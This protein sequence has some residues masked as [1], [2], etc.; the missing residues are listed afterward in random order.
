MDSKEQ[1]VIGENF[2]QVL[3]YIQFRHGIQGLTYLGTLCDLDLED[4]REEKFYPFEDFLALLTS[5]LR[6]SNDYQITY[7]IGLHRAKNLVLVKGLKNQGPDVLDKVAKAWRRF[8]NFGEVSINKHDDGKII[9][10]ISNYKSHP[11]YCKR[12][13]GF[14]T[15]LLKNGNKG[16]YNVKEINCVCHGEKACEFEIEKCT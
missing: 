7:K 11:L 14:L 16:S 13:L 12:L 4:F 5:V 9:F 1:L 6:M 3:D 2:L 8:N 10:S 15:G